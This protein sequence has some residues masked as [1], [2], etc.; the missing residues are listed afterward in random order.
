MT[1]DTFKTLREFTPAPGK[2]AKY[3]SLAALEAAQ[4][5]ADTQRPEALTILR[6]LAE[7]LGPQ[8]DLGKAATQ[9]AV[10]LDK[11]LSDLSS[12]TQDVAFRSKVRVAGF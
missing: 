8:T 12:R 6:Q 5:L 2:T 11:R 1:Q 9:A 10:Y 4:A 7:E 3:H